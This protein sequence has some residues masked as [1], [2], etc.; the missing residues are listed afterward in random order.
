MNAG[1]LSFNLTA[2]RHDVERVAIPPHCTGQK[3]GAGGC[4]SRGASGCEVCWTMT[5][6]STSSL[7]S[8]LCTSSV[9]GTCAAGGDV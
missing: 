5:S 4:L 8:E 9:K 6:V 7:I 1:C 3:L 2:L